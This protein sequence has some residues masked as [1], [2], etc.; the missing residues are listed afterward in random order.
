METSFGGL[1]WIQ[2]MGDKKIA[3]MLLVIILVL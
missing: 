1:D 3:N 2:G